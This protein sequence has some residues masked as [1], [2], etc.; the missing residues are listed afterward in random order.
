MVG[1][2]DVVGD[3]L[4]GL[5]RHAGQRLVG[6]AEQGG[7]QLGLVARED[8]QPGHGDPEVGLRPLDEVHAAEL[9]LVAPVGQ[10]VLTAAVSLEQTGVGEQRAGLAELVEA[11]VGEGD[12]L[13][14]LRRAAD[15]PPQPLG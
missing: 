6:A 8:Q 1:V 3:L 4:D 14:E 10:V 13:L 12:V 11:D 9:A 2:V 5:A 7:V 15:P